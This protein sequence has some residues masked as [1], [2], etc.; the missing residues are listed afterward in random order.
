MEK[1]KLKKLSLNLTTDRNDY[2]KAFR[3]NIDMYIAEKDITLRE[4]SEA[5]DIPYSTLN[6]FVYGNSADCKL[7]TAVKL[8]R[9]FGISIDELVGAG[10][11]EDETRTTIA[12]A[13]NLKDHHRHVI[14]MFAKHQ[15][16]L[17]GD[18]PEKS[19]QISV[20]LPECQHGHLRTTTI[21]EALNIDH[22]PQSVKTEACLGLRIPCKHYEPLFMRDETLI[23]GAHR[24][25]LNG[26]KCVVSKD[27][28]LYI[29][30]KNILT[31]DGKR[32]TNYHSVINGKLLFNYS[33]I[34]DR[35]GY[36]IGFLNPD[37]SWGIR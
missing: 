16:L 32:I 4:I 10:T 21:T 8:A 7:S 17:H 27:G 12:T 24:E 15:Y 19:K 14:R 34:D 30:K 26:E 35:V 23:L 6:T 2:M 36:V 11:I 33:D 5:A 13:R 3:K 37:G 9:A 31:I 25:G 28:N 22:L 18:V 20:M 1:E 29:C